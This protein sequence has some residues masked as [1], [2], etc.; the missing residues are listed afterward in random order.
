[1]K[2]RERNG[3]WMRWFHVGPS[4]GFCSTSHTLC[5]SAQTNIRIIHKLLSQ[6]ASLTLPPKP[7][8][9]ISFSLSSFRYLTHNTRTGVDFF[10][11]LSILRH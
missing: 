5:E 2:K 8:H 11:S 10:Q 9:L 3:Q 7:S 6:S 1:L 4:D